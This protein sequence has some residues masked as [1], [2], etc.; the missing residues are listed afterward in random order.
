MS[1]ATTYVRP[2]EERD[3]KDMVML[4]QG[5]LR[6]T[7]CPSGRITPRG[8]VCMHCGVDYTATENAGFCGQPLEDDGYTPFD[9][10]VARRIMQDSERKFRLTEEQD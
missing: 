6:L 3:T 5:M 10:T 2:T 1:D 9:A 4:A 7:R 8:Y